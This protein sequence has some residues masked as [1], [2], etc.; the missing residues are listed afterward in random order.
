MRISP[1][2]S[3][4][5]RPSPGEDGVTEKE[6]GG[7]RRNRRVS[8]SIFYHLKENQLWSKYSKHLLS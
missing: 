8:H 2:K 7:K 5:A 3:G 6:E 4:T 1:D